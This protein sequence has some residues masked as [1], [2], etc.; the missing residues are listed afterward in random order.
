MRGH[1]Q[2]FWGEGAAL[3]LVC[4]GEGL[5]EARAR[6]PRLVRCVVPQHKGLSFSLAGNGG[7]DGVW[8]GAASG[9]PPHGEAG[10]GGRFGG[11]DHAAEEALSPEPETEEGL[12][13][14]A[15]WNRH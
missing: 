12:R 5:P 14:P 8:E 7:R 10:R 15:F 1:V 4:P 9:T 3:L 13:K 2:A 6:R 11:A